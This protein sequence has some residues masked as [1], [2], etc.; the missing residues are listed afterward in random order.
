MFIA[1]LDK[2]SSQATASTQARDAWVPDADTQAEVLWQTL[3][4][5]VLSKWPV[6]SQPRVFLRGWPATFGRLT[7]SLWVPPTP[8]CPRHLRGAPHFLQLMVGTT[9]P[10]DTT[11]CTQ[12]FPLSNK[13]SPTPGPA[14]EDRIISPV[15]L[16]GTKPWATDLWEGLPE[17]M[18]PQLT[19]TRLATRMKAQANRL[20]RTD[21]NQ[22]PG[23]T[24]LASSFLL[25]SLVSIPELYTP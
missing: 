8:S 11:I 6:I 12:T 25:A 21:R 17:R 20:V 13:F 22:H 7:V 15:T 4:G 24:H 19:L 9:G 1:Q 3:A 16:T 23:A 5:N 10:Q 14:K 18:G 2:G